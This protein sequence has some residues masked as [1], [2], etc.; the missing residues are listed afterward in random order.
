MRAEFWGGNVIP[1]ASLPAHELGGLA[2]PGA[3]GSHGR[4]VQSRP[5]ALCFF[6]GA[7][8]HRQIQ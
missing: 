6:S 8:V 2:V 7:F 5:S 1:R 4:L 3:R